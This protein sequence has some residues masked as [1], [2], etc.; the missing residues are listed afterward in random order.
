VTRYVWDP[1]TKK[2][3]SG[4]AAPELLREDLRALPSEFLTKDI[5][6]G[7]RIHEIDDP[8]TQEDLKDQLQEEK[9]ALPPLPAGAPVGE[10]VPLNQWQVDLV[11][12]RAMQSVIHAESRKAKPD[13]SVRHL[14]FPRNNVNEYA[15]RRGNPPS[16]RERPVHLKGLRLEIDVFEWPARLKDELEAR[17]HVLP[18]LREEFANG[19]REQAEAASSG[20]EGMGD[21]L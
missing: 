17:G 14:W 11:R 20:Q 21:E 8:H 3:Q 19:Q 10:V 18:N 6:D 7:T 15:L 13:L 9:S 12:L 16:D 2:F 4:K 1:V 5:E